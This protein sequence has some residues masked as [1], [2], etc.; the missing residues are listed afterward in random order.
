MWLYAAMSVVSGLRTY[1]VLTPPGDTT[2]P[3]T[4]SS[5]RFVPEGVADA[6]NALGSDFQLAL[7]ESQ[8]TGYEN[9]TVDIHI[10]P[11]NEDET[12]AAIGQTTQVPEVSLD[13]SN[14]KIDYDS[15]YPNPLFTAESGGSE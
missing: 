15:Y 6:D 1:P 14:A 4:L 9:P 8:V 12:L 3:D 5:I 2:S 11:M 7:G 13:L 10:L